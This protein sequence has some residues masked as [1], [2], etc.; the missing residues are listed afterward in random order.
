MA[1]EEKKADGTDKKE[2][3]R[4]RKWWDSPWLMVIAATTL[5]WAGRHFD[6][7]PQRAEHQFLVATPKARGDIFQGAVVF[8]LTHRHSGAS[9]IILNKP[10]GKPHVYAGGPVEKDKEIAL[11]SLDV[12]FPDT[13]VLKDAGIGLLI[14]DKAVAELEGAAKKP[15]W[16]HIYQGHAGWGAYQ[17]ENEIK[18]GEW[19]L[20]EFDKDTLTK[21]PAK[22]LAKAVQQLP[23]LQGH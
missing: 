15:G 18:H 6:N 1:T 9:G 14:G 2:K 5:L 8:V 13:V 7:S 16:F 21:T 11:Q 4:C 17:L 22:D 12:A 19:Q 20:V 10:S 23:I 3:T